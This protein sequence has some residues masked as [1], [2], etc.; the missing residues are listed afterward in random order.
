MPRFTYPWLLLLLLFVPFLALY[1]RRRRL[2]AVRYPSVLTL[3]ALPGVRARLARWGRIG[4]QAGALAALIA[5]LAGPRWPDPHTRVKTAGI[6]IMMAADTSGS[7]GQADF[8]WQSERITR[9]EAVKRAFRL[10]V[11]G[12]QSGSLRLP[13]RPDDEIGLVTFGT[14]PEAVCPLTLSHS[15]L[16]HLLDQERPRTIPTESQTN[17]GDAIAWGLHGLEGSTAK[18]KVMVLLSDGEHNVPP[19]ALKPRQ[20]AQLAANLQ[21]PVYT[22]DCG[23]L[24]DDKTQE[25]AEMSEAG[26]QSLEAVARISG[27]KHF[28]AHDAASLLQVCEEIDRLER[29]PLESFEYRRYYEAY[30][31]FGL[32]GFCLLAGLSV[33][34][35]TWWRKLP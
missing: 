34:E 24:L 11:S 26:H 8:E 31:W 15:A 27:G 9:L 25:A 5:A 6:A 35:M 14:R 10:F 20:A 23:G 22:I 7:M 12:G 4:L 2:G 18:R 16:L 19:P 21:V 29:R 3:A 32:A 33:L 28:R 17:I 13:G 1:W 30:P